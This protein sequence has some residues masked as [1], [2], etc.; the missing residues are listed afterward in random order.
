MLVG[1]SE[2]KRGE[3]RCALIRW[4]QSSSATATT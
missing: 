1:V 4:P 2:I 3:R